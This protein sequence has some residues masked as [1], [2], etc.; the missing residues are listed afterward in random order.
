MFLIGEKAARKGLIKKLN[1]IVSIDKQSTKITTDFENTMKYR[2][3][4]LDK[5]I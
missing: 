4:Q 3:G 2:R 1:K 5:F